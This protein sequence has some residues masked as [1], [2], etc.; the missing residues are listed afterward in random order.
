MQSQDT[1]KYSRCLKVELKEISKSKHVKCLRTAYNWR[2]F[3]FEGVNE[4][5]PPP[6][7]IFAVHRKYFPNISYNIMKCS[8]I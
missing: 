5:L 4:Q 6:L 8:V 1:F 3:N 2:L 7:T